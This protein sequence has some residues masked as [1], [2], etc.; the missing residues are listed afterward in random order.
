MNAYYRGYL[1]GDV[2]RFPQW[3]EPLAV[4]G[5]E[6][7]DLLDDTIVYLRDDF[8]VVRSPVGADQGV[9]WDA[10]T[11]QW[12]EFCDTVLRFRPPRESADGPA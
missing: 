7:A 4:A 2:R 9:L 6:D 10:M 5:H 1:L 12:R 11:P 8:A 3:S